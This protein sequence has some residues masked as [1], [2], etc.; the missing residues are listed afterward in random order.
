MNSEG[1]DGERKDRLS[2]E[3][4]ARRRREKVL[5]RAKD[6]NEE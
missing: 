4:L 2:E 3:E 1:N 5:S 6:F